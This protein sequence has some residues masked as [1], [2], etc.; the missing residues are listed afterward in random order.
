MNRLRKYQPQET[1]K[2]VSIVNKPG[3]RISYNQKN[4]FLRKGYKI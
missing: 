4:K 3:L 2:Q 1:W